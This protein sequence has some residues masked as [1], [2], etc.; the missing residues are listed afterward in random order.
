MLPILVADMD[1]RAVP[2]IIE[3]IRGKVYHG[4][5]GYGRDPEFPV[6]IKK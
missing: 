6:V 4:V 3:A 1:F 5:F 2:L